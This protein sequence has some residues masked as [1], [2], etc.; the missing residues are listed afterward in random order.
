M[1]DASTKRQEHCDPVI[2][3]ILL[4][5]RMFRWVTS[6]SFPEVDTEARKVHTFELIRTVLHKRFV[7]LV[8]AKLA[9]DVG[10]LIFGTRVKGEDV[11]DG[12]YVSQE[13]GEWRVVEHVSIHHRNT[14]Q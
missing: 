9:F 5:T 10:S 13:N 3:A 8:D 4:F 14:R 7:L 1:S 2:S 11:V 12:I 6:R